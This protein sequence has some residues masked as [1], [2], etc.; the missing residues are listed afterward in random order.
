MIVLFVSGTIRQISDFP[1]IHTNVKWG[2]SINYVIGYKGEVRLYIEYVDEKMKPNFDDIIY[3]RPLLFK[4][5][6][7]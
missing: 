3:E 2:S 7:E 6:S 1:R 5:R 4:Y